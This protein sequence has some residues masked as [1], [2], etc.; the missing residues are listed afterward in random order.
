MDLTKYF[1]DTFNAKCILTDHALKRITERFMYS[2]LSKLKLLVQASV[3][4]TPLGKWK[5]EEQTVLIDPRFNFSILCEYYPDENIMKII[6]F[7]RGKTPEAYKNCKTIVV[8]ILKEQSEQEVMA[9]N[10]SRKYKF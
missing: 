1:S 7:I 10:Q 8:S 3:K 9:L 4:N 5:T 2:D 6:T